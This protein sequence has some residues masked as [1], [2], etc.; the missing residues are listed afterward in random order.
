MWII[1]SVICFYG[2]ALSPDKPLCWKDAVV[3]MEF[4]NKASCLL[5]RDRLAKDLDV[6]L[7]ARNVKLSL[8]CK[9]ITQPMDI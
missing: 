6:D 8:Q 9:E 3:P 1:T 5:V 7:N 4:S 2:M